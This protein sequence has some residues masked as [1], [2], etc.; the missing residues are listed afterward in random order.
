VPVSTPP[1]PSFV[2][3]VVCVGFE[4]GSPGVASVAL[5]ATWTCCVLPDGVVV[6]SS[7]GIGARMPQRGSAPTTCWVTVPSAAVSVRLPSGCT[8]SVVVSPLGSVIVRLRSPPGIA[9]VRKVVSRPSP[10]V[11]LTSVESVVSVRWNCWTRPVE[12][13]SWLTR[14]RLSYS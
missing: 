13:V 12:L 14:P 3:F 2:T 11:T 10:L 5:R 4:N 1:A 8:S 9:S 6:V 7:N